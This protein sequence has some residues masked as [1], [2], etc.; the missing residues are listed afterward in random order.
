MKRIRHIVA[1]LMLLLSCHLCFS[2]CQEVV[3]PS[4]SGVAERARLEVDRLHKAKKSKDYRI[5]TTAL[6]WLARN[7]PRADTNLYLDADLIYGDLLS[8]ERNQTVKKLYLDSIYR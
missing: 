8:H 6:T 2:Q 3:W 4:D 7:A 1:V 5:A